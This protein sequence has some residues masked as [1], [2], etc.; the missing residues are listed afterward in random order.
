MLR[1][2]GHEVTGCTRSAER[3]SLIR[4]L[5]AEPVVA[6]AFDAEAL[7]SAV[8]EARPEAVIH[9]LTSIPKAVD[10]KRFAEQFEVNNR[11]RSQGTRNLVDAAVAAGATRLIAQSIAFAYAQT[12][13]LHSEDDPLALDSP[14]P[15]G[16][17]VSALVD[18]EQ[19][20]TQ[21]EGIDGIVLRYGYFYGPGTSFASDGAQSELVR[22]RRFPLVGKSEGV[23][24]FIHID[25]AAAATVRS[26]DQ[27]A[28]GIYNIVDDEPAEVNQWLPYLAEVLGAPRP[29]KVPVFLARM[30]GGSFGVQY[31]TRTEGAANEKAKRE[32]GLGLRY[33][34]WRQ[35]FREALG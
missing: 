3:A 12:G 7:K 22:R 14:G 24:S 34:S 32:L 10:P 21:T 19:A 25:D 18:L 11:L 35:G 23:F 15:F 31:M 4:D 20:V 5:G 27:G 33:P 8:V 9:Q 1:E 30:F 26:L 13:R 2:A 16:D 6:D 28:P 17:T 29:R